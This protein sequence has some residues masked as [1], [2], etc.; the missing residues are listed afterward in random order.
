M[1]NIIITGRL[2][3]DPEIRDVRDSKAMKFSMAVERDYTD[4]D[5]KK[6]VDFI[7]V[8]YIRKDFSKLA[9]YVK[10][11]KM[12]LVSGSLNIDEVEGKYYTKVK[13]SKI[14]LLGGKESSP[15]HNTHT[16]FSL[17]NDFSSVEDDD[18]PF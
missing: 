5:G 9:P 10:K 15:E 7:P 1:N 16:E 3:K 6:P 18:I 8:E 11:G 13:A 17:E 14:E 4:K 12:V 2:T